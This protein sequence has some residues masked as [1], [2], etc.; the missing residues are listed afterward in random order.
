MPRSE[1]NPN[2]VLKE[3]ND[4]FIQLREHQISEANKLVKLVFLFL[5]GK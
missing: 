3:I 1:T 5:N 4:E 2:A